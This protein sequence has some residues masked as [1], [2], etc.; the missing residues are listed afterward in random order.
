MSTAETSRAVRAAAHPDV[1]LAHRMADLADRIALSW[2]GR[3]PVTEAKADGSPVSEAD[4]AVEAA[5][6]DLLAKERPGDGVLAEESGS[7]GAPTS[8][9]WILDPIDGTRSYLA[10]TRA[11]GTHIA[12]EVEGHLTVAVFTR[13][14][15]GLR[16]WALSGAGAYRSTTNDPLD[17]TRPLTLSRTARLSDARVGGL[18]DPGSPCAAALA[19]HVR[20]T[21]D[22]VSVIAAL[23]EGR[24][25]AVLDDGG[26]AWDQ[27]PAVLLVQ[28]AGGLFRDPE[29][30]TRPDLGWGL[31]ANARLMAE[32]MNIV[33]PPKMHSTPA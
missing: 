24:L 33:R 10:G 9:R 16:W 26:N 28:E 20:W 23:L 19:P 14:V 12:L 7:S 17:T 6:L 25:D 18:V 5:L 30:G 22:E 11:W 13:P 15:E 3:S 21:E 2:F 4:L 31:Y 8:R 32:L 29:G 27:A 1:L